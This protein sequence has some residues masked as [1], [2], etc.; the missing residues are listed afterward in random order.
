MAANDAA[1]WQ[2]GDTVYIGAET[3]QITC[4]AVAGS[5]NCQNSLASFDIVDVNHLPATTYPTGT[6]V[7]TN[8]ACGVAPTDGG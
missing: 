7:G 6:P 2:A 8:S 1:G 5:T 4:V 3:F